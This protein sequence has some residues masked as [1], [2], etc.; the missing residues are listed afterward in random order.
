MRVSKK[1]RAMAEIYKRFSIAHQQADFSEEAALAMY[2]HETH[3]RPLAKGEKLNGF[4]LGK[5]LMDVTVAS[6]K[7]DIAS[8]GL[9]VSELI[10]DGY[11]EWFLE[12]IGVLNLRAEWPKCRWW[13]RRLT[14]R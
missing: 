9:L 1:W 2:E 10:E 4:E 12:R 14:Q 13:M 5:R 8:R 7:E 3:G 6:W 11:P